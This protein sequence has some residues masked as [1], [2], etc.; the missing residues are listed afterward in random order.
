MRVATRLQR[1]A[2]YASPSCP[3]NATPP[4]SGLTR[5]APSPLSSRASTGSNPA[6]HRAKNSDPLSFWGAMGLGR[7]AYCF[8]DPLSRERMSVMSVGMTEMRMM[9]P[10]SSPKCSCTAGMPPMK[11]PRSVKAVDHVMPPITL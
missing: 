7:R 8:L 9:P 1:H 10:T 5:R 3:K 4:L 6:A 11:Y 2:R